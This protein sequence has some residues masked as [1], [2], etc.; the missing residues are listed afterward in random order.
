MPVSLKF[1]ST[2]DY[3]R[4][5]VSGTRIEGRFADEMLEAWARVAD[6]CRAHRHTRIL[7]VS[8]LTGA[9][10]KSDLFR[11]G[12]LAPKMLRDSGCRRLA[13]VVLGGPEALEALKFGETV[14][15][16]RGQLTQVFGDEASAVAWLM[17]SA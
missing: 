4:F 9:I 1:Q 14:A 16:N 7:G 12:E 10:P 8:T 3:L 13:Y 5:E 11:V 15:V 2:A 6:E 17:E